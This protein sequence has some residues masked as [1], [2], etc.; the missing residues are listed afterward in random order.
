MIHFLPKRLKSL[1]KYLATL[2]LHLYYLD[3]FYL[4]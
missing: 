4:E 3:L 2:P 1:Q